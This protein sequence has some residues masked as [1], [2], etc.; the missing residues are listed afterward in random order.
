MARQTSGMKN[1]YQK[2]ELK[3]KISRMI[4]NLLDS[5]TKK[6]IGYELH[7]AAH[8]ALRQRCH[9]SNIKDTET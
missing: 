1:F 6:L 8:E 5:Q 7:K 3:K 9:K 4:H 2:V